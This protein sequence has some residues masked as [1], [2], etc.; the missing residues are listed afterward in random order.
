MLLNKVWKAYLYY[1]AVV[2][3]LKSMHN[4]S[5]KYVSLIRTHDKLILPNHFCIF[6]PPQLRRRAKTVVS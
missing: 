4:T 6:C 3:G 2:S 5:K 1:H